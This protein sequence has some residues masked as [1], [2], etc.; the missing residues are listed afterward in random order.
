MTLV[1]KAYPKA[2]CPDCQ[3]V[4]PKTAVDGSACKNCGHVFYEGKRDQFDVAVDGLDEFP[5]SELQQS[6][7]N[8]LRANKDDIIEALEGE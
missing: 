2:R 8:Y 1:Q 6:L 5:L 3:T 7:V 4:I